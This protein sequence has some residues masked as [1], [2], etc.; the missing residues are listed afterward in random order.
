MW[1]VL[2]GILIGAAATAAIFAI[3][4]TREP[5]HSPRAAAIYVHSARAYY[6]TN[7]PPTWIIESLKDPEFRARANYELDQIDR[8]APR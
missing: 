7:D 8:I 3:Q 4:T 2:A 5:D 6:W 1:R